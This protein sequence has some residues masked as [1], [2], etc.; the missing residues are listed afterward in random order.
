MS[1]PDAMAFTT[2]KQ[3]DNWFAR[4]RPPPPTK[5][6]AD[7]VDG[8]IVAHLM[9]TA[10]DVAALPRYSEVNR[11]ACCDHDCDLDHTSR[12][13]PLDAAHDEK[14]TYHRYFIRTG[15]IL[16]PDETLLRPFRG[17]VVE[18]HFHE[19]K[20]NNGRRL[21]TR[22]SGAR[23]VPRRMWGCD[24]HTTQGCDVHARARAARRGGSSF[25]ASRR[26]SRFS[27]RLASRVAH[28]PHKALRIE[29]L[30]LATLLIEHLG[31]ELVEHRKELIKFA[32]N[33]LKSDDSTSKQWA[34]INVCR[35]IE[36]YETPPKIILQVGRW[37]PASRRCRVWSVRIG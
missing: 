30:K 3:S 29:L 4:A 28:H 31:R 22:P 7:V 15:D 20:K 25:A 33:H 37:T 13:V 9:R 36:V 32:W 26:S 23:N 11:N 21:T 2:T 34:Y 19:R 27:S 5:R 16:C 17:V 10:L 18:S 6:N 8:D 24:M 14:L 35:F 1:Y 12:N